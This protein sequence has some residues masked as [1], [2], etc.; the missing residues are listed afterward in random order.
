MTINRSRR[1]WQIP[2]AAACA[3]AG[4]LTDPH[5]LLASGGGLIIVGLLVA[6]VVTLAPT[7]M[8]SP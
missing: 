5:R 7:S 6:I 8:P 3:G 2:P 1:L 4:R